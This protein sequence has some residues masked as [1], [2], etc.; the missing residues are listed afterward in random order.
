MW[1][2]LSTVDRLALC[3]SLGW[4]PHH[5]IEGISCRSSCDSIWMDLHI[6]N[7]PCGIFIFVPSFIYILHSACNFQ[8]GTLKPQLFGSRSSNTI[9]ALHLFVLL[10]PPVTPL[11]HDFPSIATL[12]GHLC[13]SESLRYC[14]FV[15]VCIW[16]SMIVSMVMFALVYNFLYSHFM[17][18]THAYV[19]TYVR[20]EHIAIAPVIEVWYGRVSH[21]TCTHH[22]KLC[23]TI[24]WIT[25]VI[26]CSVQCVI[27]TC[28]NTETILLR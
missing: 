18:S 10:S 2:S 27:K 3:I 5:P 22:V 25:R 17:S 19:R 24:S 26:A 9:T 14:C 20:T 7:Q 16:Y 6:L 28:N 12:V 23:D 13:Q 11:V 8:N 4:I 21:D 1:Q 15:V